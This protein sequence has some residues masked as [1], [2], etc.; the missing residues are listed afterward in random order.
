[1]HSIPDNVIYNKY[2]LRRFEI[3]CC[4]LDLAFLRLSEFNRR[5]TGYFKKQVLFAN[6]AQLSSRVRR[7]LC[8]HPDLFLPTAAHYLSRVFST[9]DSGRIN[10]AFA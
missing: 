6:A 7:R 5:L 4:K 1:M 10:A 3:R 8:I 9:N 2:C